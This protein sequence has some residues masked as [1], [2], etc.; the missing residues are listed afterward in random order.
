MECPSK[1]HAN[2]CDTNPGDTTHAKNT[3]KQL[4]TKMHEANNRTNMVHKKHPKHK[5]ARNESSYLRTQQPTVTSWIEKQSTIQMIKQTDPARKIHSQAQPRMKQTRE[6]RG[7]TWYQTKKDQE[8][9]PGDQERENTKSYIQNIKN[10]Q[11]HKTIEQINN[12]NKPPDLYQLT[13]KELR[14]QTDIILQINIEPQDKKKEQN[15]ENANA[16]TEHPCPTCPYV[17][18]KTHHLN[19]HSQEK[20]NAYLSGNRNK[21]NYGNAQNRNANKSITPKKN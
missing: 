18:Q 1:I 5:H 6:Q 11:N 2:I 9:E 17:G 12:T 13:D 16:G 8:K 3:N 7:K 21:T 20:H 10:K 15:P 4:R 19:R 14:Q